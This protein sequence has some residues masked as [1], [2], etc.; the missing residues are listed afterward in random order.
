M[1]ERITER[2]LRLA[3]GRLRVAIDGLTAAGKTSL[4]ANSQSKSALPGA[5]YSGRRL[6]F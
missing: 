6:R 4:G 1:V 5:R 3:A 2:I